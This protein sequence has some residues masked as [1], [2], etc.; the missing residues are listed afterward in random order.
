MEKTLTTC[1]PANIPNVR[2]ELAAA[3][4]GEGQ[5]L[6]KIVVSIIRVHGPGGNEGDDNVHLILA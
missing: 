2:E 3:R 4:R 6:F 1:H 5:T